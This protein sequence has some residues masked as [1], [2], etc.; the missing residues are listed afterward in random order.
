MDKQA[1]NK[2]V[3][4]CTEDADRRVFLEIEQRRSAEERVRR[5]E[6]MLSESQERIGAL[7]NRL[8]EMEKHE[9][10]DVVDTMPTHE[11]VV[12]QLRSDIGKARVTK[13]QEVAM[14]PLRKAASPVDRCKRC[15]DCGHSHGSCNS[16][17]PIWGRDWSKY[18]DRR[19]L[20]R[21]RRRPEK[22]RGNAGSETHGS[23]SGARET[24]ES[25]S[26]TAMGR[27]NMIED[28]RQADMMSIT[29]SGEERPTSVPREQSAC[30]DTTG[31]VVGDAGFRRELNGL[32][33]TCSDRSRVSKEGEDDTKKQ[34]STDGCLKEVGNLKERE[35]GV[36]RLGQEE[37][38]KEVAKDG[39][40]T[41]TDPDRR[42][43]PSEGCT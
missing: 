19:R 28:L 3:S 15:G 43:S 20:S 36:R 5:A 29:E 25:T 1:V 2:A 26:A 37:P 24:V 11:T 30:V 41:R 12:L 35:R 17:R 32:Q 23:A 9:A 27:S 13:Q 18:T 33:K 34:T 31:G 38:L 8:S 14:V 7:V 22:K 42:R 39:Q 40:A 16:T 10:I 6:Q 4:A 21:R